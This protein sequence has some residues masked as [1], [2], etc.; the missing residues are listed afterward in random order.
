[1]TAHGSIF[2]VLGL[3]VTAGTAVGPVIAGY[4]F[5]ITDGYR[6]AFLVTM[7]VCI[8]GLILTA[9]TNSTLSKPPSRVIN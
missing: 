5:D 3:G 7:M 8:A 1:M 4:L 2:G 9:L 6:I